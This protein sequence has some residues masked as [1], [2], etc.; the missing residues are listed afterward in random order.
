[1]KPFKCKRTLTYRQH[2]RKI[3][4]YKLYVFDKS[5][6]RSSILYAINLIII[7]LLKISASCIFFLNFYPYIDV[8]NYVRVCMF[9]M[10]SDHNAHVQCQIT[11]FICRSV[12]CVVYK[13]ESLKIQ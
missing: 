9:V 8:Y 3:Q 10:Y 13:K 1:M 6:F 12:L 5:M 11:F 2:A 7:R 4:H